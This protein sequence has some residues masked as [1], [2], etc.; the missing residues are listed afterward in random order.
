MIDKGENKQ[1]FLCLQVRGGL[2]IGS[3]LIKTFCIA[4]NEQKTTI[5]ETCE[6]FRVT[7]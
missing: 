5:G 3:V 6:G 2:K 1:I 4:E 7:Q